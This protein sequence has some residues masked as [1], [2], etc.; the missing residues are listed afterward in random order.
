MSE[1]GTVMVV[2][3][4]R[5]SVPGVLARPENGKG[6]TGQAG[7]AAAGGSGVQE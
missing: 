7:S 5:A 1:R 2:K 3:D 4:L 6:W